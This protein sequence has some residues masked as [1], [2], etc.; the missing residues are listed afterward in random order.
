[1]NGDC[2]APQVSA[3]SLVIMGD[4]G[5]GL[6]ELNDDYT[7]CSTTLDMTFRRATPS[8]V[9]EISVNPCCGLTLCLTDN[10]YINPTTELTTQPHDEAGSDIY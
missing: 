4:T 6:S 9:F 3:S 7:V 5:S 2:A 1:M 10:I 8:E